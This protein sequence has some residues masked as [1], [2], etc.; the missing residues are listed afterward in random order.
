MA[1][2]RMDISKKRCITPEFRLSFPNLLKAK[3]YEDQEAKYSCVG[4]F[5][6]DTNFGKS[7][8]NKKGEVLSVSMKRAFK[9]ACI[10]KWGE[11]EANWPTD[12]KN[13]KN[14]FRDGSERAD[15][16]GYENTVFVTF[17]NTKAPGLV[18]ERLKAVTDEEKLYP[19]CWCR[20]EVI[21]FAFSKKGNKGVSFSLQNVQKV[22]DDDSFSSKKSA[23]DVFDRV[24]DAEDED[25]EEHDSEDEGDE[26]ERPA[27]KKK[28]AAPA[29][30]KSRRD[31]EDD[32]DESDEDDDS[33][34]DDE[35]DEPA[36]KKKKKPAPKAAAKKKKRPS[37]DEDEDDDSD[38][39]DDD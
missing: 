38:D 30:K 28:K 5:P 15:T 11:D 25:D 23:Q 37:R 19:G 17:S 22:R 29:K 36:P 35:E 24:D 13:F 32:E 27:K 10:E 34:E 16:D 9:N 4:L 2:E 33:D 3:A 12:E 39:E 14:P 6:D 7:P 26:D 8:R 21:A 31:E 1:S 18:D 20:A